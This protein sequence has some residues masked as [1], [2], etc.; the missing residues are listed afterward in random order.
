[1]LKRKDREKK[2]QRRKAK[3][4]GLLTITEQKAD[5]G[6]AEG[7]ARKIKELRVFLKMCCQ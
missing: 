4:L 3:S 7:K 1:V 6:N 5:K 2:E